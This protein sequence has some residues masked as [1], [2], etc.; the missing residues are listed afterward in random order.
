MIYQFLYCC[1]FESSRLL[2][3]DELMISMDMVDAWYQTEYEPIRDRDG[4]VIGML[5]VGVR[6]ALQGILDNLSRIVVGKTGCIWIVNLEGEYVLSYQRRRD[7]EYIADTRDSDGRQFIQ[8]WLR[9]ARSF[10]RARPSSTT[11]PGKIRENRLP[12]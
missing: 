12:E 2:H 11:I 10:N 9:R 4:K 1:V 8:E 7:G 3:I 5:Y 6:D